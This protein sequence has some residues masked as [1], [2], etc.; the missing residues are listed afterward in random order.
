MLTYSAFTNCMTMAIIYL[1][2]MYNGG[3]SWTL[4]C[5]A[6]I[7]VNIVLDTNNNSNKM[8]RQYKTR[9]IYG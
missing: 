1:N 4:V 7:V 8:K 2:G 5:K 9:G 3:I 6:F